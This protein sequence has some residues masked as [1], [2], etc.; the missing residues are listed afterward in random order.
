MSHY[1]KICQILLKNALRVSNKPSISI[2]YIYFYF[3]F[4]FEYFFPAFFFFFI[5]SKAK[6]LSLTVIFALLSKYFDEF[7]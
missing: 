7:I 2:N 3:F 1:N 5:W 4:L 6:L